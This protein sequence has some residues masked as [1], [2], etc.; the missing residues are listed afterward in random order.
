MALIASETC[1]NIT[2]D[3]D[4]KPIPG[5]YYES[6]SPPNI[7]VS[8]PKPTK[9]LQAG[10]SN[11]QSDTHSPK[12]NLPIHPRVHQHERQPRRRRPQRRPHPHLP[13]SH[14]L[15]L[16]PLPPRR[17]RHGLVPSDGQA[18]LLVHDGDEAILQARGAVDEAAQIQIL[19]EH[20]GGPVLAPAA[21]VGRDAGEAVELEHEGFGRRGEA[22]ELHVGGALVAAAAV[23]GG[24]DGVEVARG[25]VREE[26]REGDRG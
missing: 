13:Y 23:A 4:A 18:A 2:K 1:E 19:P 25:Q 15:H 26:V 8:N 5:T 9:T 12:T 6:Y 16:L 20:D 10:A 14:I 24:A 3:D 17:L 11:F 21:A 22:G 7:A